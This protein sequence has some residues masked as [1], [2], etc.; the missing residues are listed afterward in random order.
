MD[1]VGDEGPFIFFIDIHLRVE[2]EGA[3]KFG[4]LPLATVDGGEGL[5]TCLE[6]FLVLI[7]GHEI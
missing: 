4:Y 5:M 7:D 2:G 3:L 6:L 1:V